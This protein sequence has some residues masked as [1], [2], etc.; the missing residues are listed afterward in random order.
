MIKE[1][2]EIKDITMRNDE[3]NTE[4]EGKNLQKNDDPRNRGFKIKE[5]RK[6]GSH[7]LL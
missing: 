5:R 6:A 3:G 7:W 4:M 1:A 2:L